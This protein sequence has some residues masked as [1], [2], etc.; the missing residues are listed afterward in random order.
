MAATTRTENQTAPAEPTDRA[1]GREALVAVF[2][3]SRALP[4]PLAGEAYGRDW[5]AGHGISD[6]KSSRRHCTFERT[7]GHL[8]LKDLCSKNGT[9]VDGRRVV[10]G[11]RAEL[12]DGSTVRT[13]RTVFVYRDDLRG[14]DA[15]SSPLGKMV[16][17]FGLRQTAEELKALTQRSPANI[18]IEGET[19]TGK[20]LL[21]AEVGERLGRPLVAVNMAAV[22][23]SVFEA[24]LF[25]HVEGAFTGSG[26]GSKGVLLQHDRGAV[27]LDEIG[28]LPLEL[29]PK[30]LRVL[31]NREFL[32]VGATRP[33]RVDV[34]VIAATNRSLREMVEEGTFRRDLLT[35]LEQW[36]LRLPPLR[37]RREDILQISEAL[38]ATRELH[39][40]RAH[41]EAEAVERLMLARWDGNVRELANVLE[42]AVPPEGPPAL[43]LHA[44]EAA[45][46]PC[47]PEDDGAV[48]TREAVERALDLAGG[49]QS[50]AARNLG[51]SRGK[52]LRFL[53]TRKDSREES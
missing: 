43:R 25:G 10:S 47:E 48:L 21:A 39:L 3:L 52:L 20:E 41:V 35:R 29:Q 16:G 33:L 1:A 7:G 14:P 9:W 32:Q 6:P 46:G 26:R 51:V 30:L 24:T 13:A 12:R 4:V 19:G 27:L 8:Y 53:R 50:K 17:P 11:E 22:P 37:E 42:R 49:N 36:V 23:G 18:L 31:E 38:L 15:A 34:V 2:P 5:L 44:L 40:D 45:L 28:E